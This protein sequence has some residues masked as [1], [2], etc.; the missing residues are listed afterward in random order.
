[1]IANKEAIAVNQAYSGDSG[2]LVSSSQELAMLQNCSFPMNG[3]ANNCSES[4]EMVFR[5]HLTATTTAVLLVNNRATRGNVTANWTVIGVPCSE[6]GC[7]ARDVWAHTDLGPVGNATSWT[8][9]LGSHDS[10]FVVFTH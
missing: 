3:V 2:R 7:T 4:A 8:V 5:K 9:E 10:S 1:M 6:G